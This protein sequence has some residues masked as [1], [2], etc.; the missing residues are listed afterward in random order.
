MVYLSTSVKAES[1]TVRQEHSETMHLAKVL[2]PVHSDS[3]TPW[4]CARNKYSVLKIKGE[5]PYSE[6]LQ[7]ARIEVIHAVTSAKTI[8]SFIGYFSAIL[9]RTVTSITFNNTVKYMGWK[10]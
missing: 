7:N 9:K 6:M 8:T 2:D 4:D 5:N 10:K 1:G 3:P